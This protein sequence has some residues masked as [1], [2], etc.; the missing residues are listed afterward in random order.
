MPARLRTVLFNA[1]SIVLAGTLL[2]L[3]L[4]GVSFA[5]I[6]DVLAGAN[7][8]WLLPWAFVTLLSHYIRALR[9][10]ILL[11]ELPGARGPEAR[12]ATARLAFFSVMIGYM[13]NYIVPRVGEAVR[14][15]NVSAQSSL[16][17][18]GVFGTVVVGRLLDVLV[19]GV[20][21]LGMVWLFLSRFAGFQERFLDPALARLDGVPILPI[22]FGVLGAGLV[23][24]GLFV[25]VRIW[26]SSDEAPPATG[27]MGRLRAALSTFAEGLTTILR[28]PKRLQLVLLTVAMWGCYALVAHL[29]FYL[30]GMAEPYGITVIDSWG[31]M[32]LGSLGVALPSPGG[33]GTYHYVITQAL[34]FLFA[35]PQAEAVSYAVITHGFQLILYV[36]VGA[37]CLVLQGPSLRA[38]RATAERHTTDDTPRPALSSP[39]ARP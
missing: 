25:A 4:R 27:L 6:R 26:G 33:V 32:V 24:V 38:L 22:A 3:A 1:G 8:V 35:V 9:W 13:I 16:R 11:D 17:F 19:W 31:L 15:A 30:L 29:P 39:P 2:Y 37:L 7:Y 10:K 23:A 20:S 18:S 14:A 34:V 5:E 28:S 12:P 21:L 36:A